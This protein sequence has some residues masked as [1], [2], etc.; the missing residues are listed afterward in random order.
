MAVCECSSDA[1]IYATLY[2][3]DCSLMQLSNF[4]REFKQFVPHSDSAKSSEYTV[5]A[6]IL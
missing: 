5:N 4:C 1:I 3:N 6:A 2:T